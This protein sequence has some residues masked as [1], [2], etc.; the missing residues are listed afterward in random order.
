MRRIKSI[1]IVGSLR[2][3]KKVMKFANELRSHKFEV[4]DDWTAP[5]PD[6]DLY[7]WKYYK[8]R[9]FAYQ[10]MVESLAAVNN[11]SFDLAHLEK[12]DTAIMLAPC[13]RSAHLEIGWKSRTNPCFILFDKVPERPD[14]MYRILK[15]NLFFDKDK[16]IAALKKTKL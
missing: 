3:R 16:L 15:G 1:Y 2:N 10:E 9:G 7:L 8:Q 6:A 14:I 4:F 5:G 13:G 11:S 12:A